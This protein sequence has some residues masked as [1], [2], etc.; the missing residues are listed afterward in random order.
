MPLTTFGQIFFDPSRCFCTL[1]SRVNIQWQWR[2]YINETTQ[3]LSGETRKYIYIRICTSCIY[4]HILLIFNNDNDLYWHP[5]AV[6]SVGDWAKKAFGVQ[7]P[8]QTKDRTVTTTPLEHYQGTL[9]QETKP[10]TP[11]VNGACAELASRP[12]SVQL[13]LNPSSYSNQP[14]ASPAYWVV[15]SHLVSNITD[16]EWNK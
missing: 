16:K 6:Q 10:P 5:V 8:C 9:E 7:S 14:G 12:T 11:C 1:T 3:I 15:N 4:G 13:V 2:K